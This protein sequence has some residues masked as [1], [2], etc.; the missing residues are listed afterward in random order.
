MTGIE[1]IE[2]IGK[3]IN[4]YVDIFFTILKFLFKPILNNPSNFGNEP[5]AYIGNL[6]L[7][8]I[9]L[10]ICLVIIYAI[11]FVIGYL[12]IIVRF[13]Q[14]LITE[15]ICISL[16]IEIVGL[17]ITRFNNFTFVKFLGDIIGLCIIILVILSIIKIIE[18][19]AKRK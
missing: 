18:E 5:S 14:N 11:Y 3:L 15:S 13:K 9:Y 1:I 8:I 2:G 6:A 16:T 12:L 17:L 7:G 4:Y 19:F 10:I